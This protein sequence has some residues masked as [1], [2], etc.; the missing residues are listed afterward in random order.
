M[1]HTADF[2]KQ[3]RALTLKA[4]DLP[5]N[6]TITAAR[7]LDGVVCLGHTALG[8]V[9]HGAQV[10]LEPFEFA[11]AALTLECA[12]SRAGRTTDAHDAAI[13]NAT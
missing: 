8:G 7:I 10:G 9:E 2:G 5:R 3:G 13:A 1:L 11:N 12:G 4:R 6:L